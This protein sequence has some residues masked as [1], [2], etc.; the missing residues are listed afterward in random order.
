[1]VRPN[2]RMSAT[3][4][5]RQ[6]IQV[7]LVRGRIRRTCLGAHQVAHQ[8]KAARLSGT[9]RAA[10]FIFQIFAYQGGSAFFS[11]SR[12]HIQ[13][14]GQTVGELQGDGRHRKKHHALRGLDFH[15]LC[16]SPGCN[17]GLNELL[18]DD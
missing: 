10:Q 8:I 15:K 17:R 2:F 4:F 13:E 12:L 5:T 3:I 7:V 18:I 1:M 14:G 11:V 6:V 9:L 16:F